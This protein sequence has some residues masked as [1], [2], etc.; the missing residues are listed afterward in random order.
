[1]S[2]H[3]DFGL[4][5]MPSTTIHPHNAVRGLD[6]GLCPSPAPSQAPGVWG[7][8]RGCSGRVAPKLT[9]GSFPGA[10]G[11]PCQPWSLLFLPDAPSEVLAPL[12][13]RHPTAIKALCPL[14]LPTSPGAKR[15]AHSF[16]SRDLSGLD[17]AAN[18]SPGSREGSQGFFSCSPWFRA[19]SPV[20]AVP[21]G[22]RSPQLLP[23]RH[24]A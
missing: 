6:K 9:Q 22:T 18:T 10:V 13:V 21:Q 8:R 20:P 24:S 17:S 2:P 14:S 4:T 7:G 23:W 12:T 15:W 19:A 1:M 16:D 3:S 5:A 11:C